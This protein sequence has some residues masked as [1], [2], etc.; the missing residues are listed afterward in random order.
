MLT[1]PEDPPVSL[2]ELK[3][4]NPRN[5]TVLRGHYRLHDDYV[6]IVL[7]REPEKSSAT[8]NKIRNQKRRGEALRT[9]PSE[10]TF[11]LVGGSCYT[12]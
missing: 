8:N 2:K 11:H 5:T 4:R 9:E 7:K 10:Q 1:T 12:D 6:T 3:H